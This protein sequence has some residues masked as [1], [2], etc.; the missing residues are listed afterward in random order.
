MS[1]ECPIRPSFYGLLVFCMGNHAYNSSLEVLLKKKRI[2]RFLPRNSLFFQI[3]RIRPCLAICLKKRVSRPP[4]GGG[5]GLRNI[6]YEWTTHS[7]DISIWRDYSNSKIQT[8][9]KSIKIGHTFTSSVKTNEERRQLCIQFKDN[10]LNKWIQSWN[11]I[12]LP[13][14]SVTW[15]D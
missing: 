2:T 11:P 8:L 15:I 4:A 1:I 6:K 7:W 13:W 3:F 14:W 12:L 5:T 9:L 10:V